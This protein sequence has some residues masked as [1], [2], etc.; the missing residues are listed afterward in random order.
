MKITPVITEI[1]QIDAG[2]AFGVIPKS[3]WSN[4]YSVSEN[5]L[6]PISNRCLIIESNNRLILI[7]T[8]FGNKRNEKYYQ[9]KY[10]VEKTPLKQAI[11]NA[12]YNAEDF[13]D[14]IFTHLH[15]D[16]CGG[17]V[18]INESGEAE[19]VCPKANHWV[20]KKQWDSALNPNKRETAAYFN[21]NILPIFDKGLIR[22]V[23]KEMEI[24][25]DIYVLLRD[26]HTLGQ[27]LPL[28]NSNGQKWL[29]SADFIPSIPHIQAVWIS[30]VDIMPILA[31]EEKI[32]FLNKAI[33]ENI[34]LIFEHDFY[35]E[36]AKIEKD[37]KGFAGS[38]IKIN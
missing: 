28:I 16:H 37:I 2:V 18:N 23:E 12:G 24:I 4:F 3:I 14:V 13:T 26:G 1:W 6:I 33:K 22:F 21:D 11:S 8:G 10:F 17:A 32:E 35:N 20:S 15:D 25:P 5:N 31:L 27:M 9:Y 29:Y 34:N 19:I 30:S 38:Q 7:E 36:A